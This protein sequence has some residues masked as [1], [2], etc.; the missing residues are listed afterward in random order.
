MSPCPCGSGS[1]YDACCGPLIRGERSA[2]TAEAL[3]RS[4][5]SAYALVEIEHLTRSLHPQS[6]DDHDEIAAKRWA[7][8]SQWLGLE[9]CSVEQGGPEDEQGQV[10]FIATYK[11]K[12]GLQRHHEVGHFVRHEGNWYYLEGSAPKLETQQRA[13]PKLGRNDP[14]SCGSG[15]KFKKCCGA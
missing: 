15:K 9:V 6:R 8:Q 13:S 5:Y 14:C 11:N 2:A 1:E 7:E 10:E 12:Q 3:M 4:R